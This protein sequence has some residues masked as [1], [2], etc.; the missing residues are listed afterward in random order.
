MGSRLI[1][2]SLALPLLAL[3]LFAFPQLDPP[4][5][6]P[7]IGARSLALSP[8]GSRLAF[9]YRGDIWVAPATGGRAVPVTN[10]IEMDDN[11]VWSKDGKWIAFASN[12][13][14]NWDTF[15]VPAEGGETRRL[16]WHTGSD[17][18]RDW[19]AD[20]KYIVLSTT[21]EDPHNGI[22]LL[23]VKTLATRQ[24]FLDMMSVGSPQMSTDGRKILYTRFGF[25]WTRP[26]YEGSAA[27]QLWLY[28][29]PSGKREKVRATEFQHLWPHLSQDGKSVL[30]VTVTAK[31]PSSAHLGKPSVTFTDN[32][33]RTPNIYSIGLDGR[34]RRL[35]DYVGAPVRFLTV[36]SQAGTI[37][38]EHEGIVHLMR[39]GQK[40]ERVDLIATIDDKTT[41]E[42]RLILTTGADEATLSPD[43]SAIVFGIRSELWSVPTK[44]GKGPNA[45]D[46]TQL[47]DWPGVDS[48]PLFHPDGKSV[49]F[50][51]DREGP[52]SVYRM[53][54]ESKKAERVSPAGVDALELRL[55]PDA[56]R[57]SFWVSGRNGGLYTAP[58][59]G[60]AST[61]I[62][63]LPSQFRYEADTRYSWSPDSRYVAHARRQTGGTTN[64]WIFDTQTKNAVNVTKLNAFHSNPV[65]SPDGRYLYFVSNRQGSG[66]FVIPLRREEARAVEL[67]LKYEKP[68]ETPKVE[69]DFQDIE[70]RVRRLFAQNPQGTVIADDTNGDIYFVSEGDVWKASYSGEDV[71]RLT[72]GGGVSQVEQSKDRNTLLL[73][74]N[75]GLHTMNLRAPNN[76]ITAVAFRADWTRDVRAERHAAF[77]EF[78]RQYNRS[79]Y[80]P[81]FHGRNWAAIRN[82][83]EPLLDSVGHRNEMATLLNMMIGELEASHT[84]AGAGPG[85]PNSQSTAQLGFTIDYGYQGPGIRIKHVPDRAPGSYPKTKLESGEYVMAINGVDVRADE[86]LWR[87]LNEQS[88]RDITLLVSKTPTKSGAREVKYRALNSG[89]WNAIWYGNRIEA[90]RKYVEQKSGGKLTYLHISG[91]GGGN[92]DT[93]NQEAWEYIQGR[94]GVIIDVRNNGGGNIS[95]RL[96]DMLERIPHSYYQPRD[97][98]PEPAPGQAWNLPTVVLH[99]ETSFSNAEMFPYAMK[100]M[101]LATLIGMPTP[102]YVIWTYGMR[103]VDGTNARMPTSGVYRL[104]GTPLENMG[105]Q[106]DIRVDI[107]PE[108]YFAGQ[109]PQLDRAIEELMKKVK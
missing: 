96:I 90:R 75:G 56:T 18:P 3:P 46:A 19:S 99:A 44:K 54:L 27:A 16:T 93:F 8:D 65:W 24:V 109:D 72:N 7:L 12:R 74:R 84:E 69:I 63:D 103:L 35:T 51:S 58:V 78:W 92:F 17:I 77:V 32:A 47:T 2:R 33:E 94:K 34:A 11:P 62:M 52:N 55:L 104:D 9:C 50:I 106:P 85:N 26:R 30:A 108:Q 61:K 13:F 79:F 6:K 23:D 1:R 60:G 10:H 21:R 88:G 81:N 83:Y 67:E 5:P 73:V 68:K 76:P 87:A 97:G 98:E 43:G 107:T 64:I 66:L 95:D 45:D 42:E 20:G 91:M 48:D 100:Q 28:D 59:A 105:Q 29:V 71:R 70:L 86:S 22:Y 101:R 41:N 14:G 39:P 4:T 36:A 31:T 15:V 89:E 53:N 37:A 80:D 25:P 49:F 57:I 38:Y 82:R 102:G 40:A